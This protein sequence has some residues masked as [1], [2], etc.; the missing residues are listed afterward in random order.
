MYSIF[1]GLGDGCEAT[2]SASPE[3]AAEA[4]AVQ[5]NKPPCCQGAA[6]TLLEELGSGAF[7]PTSNATNTAA[8]MGG[9]AA[10]LLPQSNCNDNKTPSEQLQAGKMLI[11]LYHQLLNYFIIM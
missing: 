1:L 8:I 3:D 7:S 6:V 9:L 11:L 2:G 5:S 10:P 4:A